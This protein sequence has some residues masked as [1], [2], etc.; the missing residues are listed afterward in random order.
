MPI[1]YKTQSFREVKKSVVIHKANKY[2][3]VN[4]QAVWPQCP[5]SWSTYM[6]SLYNYMDCIINIASKI[7]AL[8]KNFKDFCIWR[9]F[10]HIKIA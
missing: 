2:N 6:I 4:N 5:H 8:Q 9:G 3:W 10:L 7:W 1:K